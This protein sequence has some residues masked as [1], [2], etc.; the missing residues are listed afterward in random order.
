[1]E[2]LTQAGFDTMDSHSADDVIFWH[3]LS[4]RNGA[5]CL[6]PWPSK[7]S[8]TNS[9]RSYE[10]DGTYR[11]R[12]WERRLRCRHTFWDIYIRGGPS[13]RISMLDSRIG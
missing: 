12:S 7:T 11:Y 8:L 6:F 10:I 9:D 5:R 1:M 2:K 4:D 3:H 13:R